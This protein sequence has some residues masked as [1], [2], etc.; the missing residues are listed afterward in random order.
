MDKHLA[1]ARFSH[2]ALSP[3]LLLIPQL[4]VT[5]I[6]RAMILLIGSSG[7]WAT[8]VEISFEIIRDLECS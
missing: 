3:A 1:S 8:M 7:A 5:I 2:R 4:A 6:L